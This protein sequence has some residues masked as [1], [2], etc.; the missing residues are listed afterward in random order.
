[1]QLRVNLHLMDP[2]LCVNDGVLVPD[3]LERQELLV[4]VWR[5]VVIP[6]VLDHLGVRGLVYLRVWPLQAVDTGDVH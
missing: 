4:M 6:Q 2:A 3:L 1:M 5:L